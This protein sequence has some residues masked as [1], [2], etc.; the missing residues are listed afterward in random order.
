MPSSELI[1]SMTLLET[2]EQV[3]LSCARAK[4][5]ERE[6][7]QLSKLLSSSLNWERLLTL[8]QH[9]GVTPL[10]FKHFLQTP[11]FP[12]VPSEVKKILKQFFRK[13]VLFSQMLS[14]ELGRLVQSFE[15]EKIPVIP[16]KGPSLAVMAYGALELRTFSDLDILMK[17]RDIPR[18]RALLLD[19]GYRDLTK[20]Q[21]TT[22]IVSTE[23]TSCRYHT[24]VDKTGMIGLDIQSKIEGG[25]FSFQIDHEEFWKDLHKV[26]VSGNSVPS[27]P[28]TK[29]LLVLCI[30]GSKHLW[31]H[32]K[33]V[34]DVAEMLRSSHQLD[35]EKTLHLSNTY[36]CKTMLLLGLNLA[37][38]LFSVSLPK[39]LHQEIQ[40]CSRISSLTNQVLLRLFPRDRP[41]PSLLPPAALFL[42][43]IDRPWDRWRYWL[44]LAIGQSPDS[45][46]TPIGPDSLMNR[47]LYMMVQPFRV[48]GKYGIPSYTLKQALARWLNRIN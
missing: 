33:W 8:A 20:S 40:N 41:N 6:V 17:N 46:H 13:H 4:L 7:H 30:H 12:H 3:L 47:F 31:C 39:Q 27:L 25:Q 38:V 18:A 45:Y 34:C 44:S 5:D 14:K 15:T 2:E 32:L 35:M 1:P 10:L 36:Q 23:Q 43:M 16:I 48:L 26:I 11:H 24:F 42:N 22:D 28:E 21:K 19:Q 29:V 9:H 37:Y